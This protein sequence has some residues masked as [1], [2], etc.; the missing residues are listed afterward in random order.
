[1]AQSLTDSV[2]EQH[3]DDLNALAAQPWEV[4]GLRLKKTFEFPDFSSAFAFMTQVAL[5]AERMNHHPE[6][7]NVYRTVEVALTTHDAEGITALDFE[8]AT[9]ME[10]AADQR[11]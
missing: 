1:V 2:V 10:R 7:R 9:I 8:L 4:Q 3:L 6:W 5:A 11:L